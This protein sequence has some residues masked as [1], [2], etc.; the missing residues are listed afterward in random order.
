MDPKAVRKTV[1]GSIKSLSALR[2]FVGPSGSIPEIAL[3]PIPLQTMAELK[4][5]INIRLEGRRRR[6]FLF[7]LIGIRILSIR[8]AAAQSSMASCVTG[9]INM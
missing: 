7:L 1:K 3:Y 5:R 6:R 4:F 2:S 9:D 8:H